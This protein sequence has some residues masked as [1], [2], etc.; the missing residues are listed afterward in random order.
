MKPEPGKEY[1]IVVHHGEGG[2][3]RELWAY[4][5]SVVRFRGRGYYLFDSGSMLHLIRGADVIEIR[6]AVPSW[7]VNM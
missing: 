7:R 1:V 3:H 6:E 4:F 2:P 5:D